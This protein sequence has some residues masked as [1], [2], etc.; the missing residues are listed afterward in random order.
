MGRPSY[1]VTSMEL[2]NTGEGFDLDDDGEVN[3]K[4][5]A[6]LTLLDLAVDDECQDTGPQAAAAFPPQAQGHARHRRHHQVDRVEVEQREGDQT[7]D[8]V[9]QQVRLGLEGVPKS[10][11]RKVTIA[12]EPVWAIGTGITAT[13]AQAQEVHLMIRRLLAE[14]YDEKLAQSL[15]IQYGGSV[16]ANNAAE[17]MNQQDIDGALVGGA[18]LK[19]A[20][21]AAIVQAVA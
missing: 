8:V 5:P 18:S 2:L 4:L 17:L 9:S 10:D 14:M 21:F 7:A 6:V 1:R 11:A 19:A 13:A 16:K 12:Y 20:D 3:N 15:R